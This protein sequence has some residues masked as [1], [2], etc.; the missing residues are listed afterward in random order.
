MKLGIFHIDSALVSAVATRA[1]TGLAG[2][3][4]LLFI[5]RFLDSVEQGY[6]YAIWSL[7]ALQSFVELGLL[8]VIVSVASH[9]WAHLSMSG[10]GQLQGS[11]RHI[12]R[13]VAL[14]RFVAAWFGLLTLLFVLAAGGAGYVFLA[15]TGHVDVSWR[16][17]WFAAIL[18]AGGVLFVSSLLA[19]LEG[20]N[21]VRQVHRLRL[22]QAIAASGALWL[23]LASGGG[24][25][26]V[27]AMLATSLLVGASY[28][29][30]RYRDF[31]RTLT[32]GRPGSDFSWRID[33]WPMQWPL[34]LQGVAAYFMYSM[35]VPVTFAY[36]GAAAAGRVGMAL[37]IGTAVSGI[38]ATWML[39]RQPQLGVLF[40]RNDTSGFRVLWRHSAL[41]CFASGLVGSAFVVLAVGVAEAVQAPLADR[42]PTLTALSLL[43]TWI[44]AGLVVQM[45]AS[46]WR[47]MKKELTGAWGF[48]PGVLTGI[49]VWGGGRYYGELGA[50][51]G[52]LLVSVV[53]TVPLA[54]IYWRIARAAL[55]T[56]AA[57]GSAA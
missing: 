16:L 11:P 35:F 55:N 14:G 6:Y 3:V 42:L 33:V 5:S 32:G 31:V 47:A 2:I 23:T 17:P 51:V 34:A 40:A 26:S 44:V 57:R 1:W 43:L 29:V 12:G 54:L 28:L 9:E 24:L 15:R 46:Y 27:G 30:I 4:T 20:C 37:Q 22:V 21:Q 50:I 41:A 39:V 19:L 18:F 56:A 7:L 38:A 10:R 36:V 52:A 49:A 45:L 48:V 8:V 25:W 53:V 13:L